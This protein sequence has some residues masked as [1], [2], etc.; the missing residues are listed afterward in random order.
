MGDLSFVTNWGMFTAIL[1]L[2][3]LGGMFSERSGIV[4]IALEGKMLMAACITALVGGVSGSPILGLSAG[5]ASAVLLSLSHWALTQF[6]QVDHIVSG[7]GINLFAYGATNFIA[8]TFIKPE[9]PNQ[10]LPIPF[11]FGCL[12]LS[13]GAS[14]F[15]F[16]RMRAGLRLLAV[17]E[18]PDKARTTGIEPLQVRLWALVLAG[19]LCGL[20]GSLIVT[21]SG[22]FGDNLTAG[23]GFIALAALI[24]GGWRPLSVALACLAFAAFEAAQIQF[25]GAPVLGYQLPAAFWKSLP[26]LITL[27]AMAGLVGRTKAPSGLGKI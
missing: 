7:M 19:I 17:G 1:G 15:M 5:L 10:F 14:W 23:R 8:L 6:Y 2:A 16:S 4:N 25:Q 26:F 20:S 13:I 24:L 12:A 18:N 27:I 3:A 21:N 9:V 11:Y 22:S